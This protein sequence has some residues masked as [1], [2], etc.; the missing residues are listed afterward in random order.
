[1]LEMYSAVSQIDEVLI[2][3]ATVAS[4]A[5]IY[6]IYLLLKLYLFPLVISVICKDTRKV[7][8]FN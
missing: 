2:F 7:S 1:M 4:G 8:I 6:F 5:T 3:F